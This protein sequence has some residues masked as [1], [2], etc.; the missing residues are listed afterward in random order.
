MSDAA[1]RRRTWIAFGLLVAGTTAF[2]IGIGQPAV[3]L[4]RSTGPGAWISG[5][6]SGW[7]V[8]IRYRPAW[9]ANLGL[10]LAPAAWFAALWFRSPVL[11]LA[12]ACA[13]AFATV[14]QALCVWTAEGEG[15]QHFLA[16]FWWW[17]ASSVVLTVAFALLPEPERPPPGERLPPETVA[18][19][20]RG[21]AALLALLGTSFVVTSL[22]VFG[23][24]LPAPTQITD[25]RLP[26]GRR[27]SLAAKAFE[28]SLLRPA[29]AAVTAALLLLPAVFAAAWRFPSRTLRWCGIAL[30]TATLAAQFLVRREGYWSS[31]FATAPYALVHWYVASAAFLVAFAVRPGT[32]PGTVRNSADRPDA[33]GAAGSARNATPPA[34]TTRDPLDS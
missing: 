3:H 23:S 25:D 27:P 21:F 30:A 14:V 34:R 20:R 29:E 26:A 8:A 22:F 32:S 7:D 5:N 15:V 11:R 12:G 19:A 31:F 1:R 16:G 28:V 10:A 6:F 18:A 9:P 2:W 24:W 13:A 4:L 17:F 33:H